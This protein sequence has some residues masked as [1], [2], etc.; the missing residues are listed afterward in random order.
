MS[1]VATIVGVTVL[2]MIAVYVLS[3]LRRSDRIP[4]PHDRRKLK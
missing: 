4:K 2:V 1:P 3:V